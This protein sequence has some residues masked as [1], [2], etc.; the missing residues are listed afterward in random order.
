MS[1]Y[2]FRSPHKISE[3]LETRNARVDQRH[4]RLARIFFASDEKTRCDADCL[5][6]DADFLIP[7]IAKTRRSPL[8]LARTDA[9]EGDRPPTYTMRARTKSAC[10][11]VSREECINK[12][13]CACIRIHP[14]RVLAAIRT[15]RT[16]ML[17]ERRYVYRGGR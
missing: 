3:R 16:G 11:H 12:T 8:S 4:A 2:F 1:D 15:T 10:S 9:S 5:R 14:L 7:D 13:P 17:R 6:Q